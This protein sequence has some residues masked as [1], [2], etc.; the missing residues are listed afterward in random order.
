MQMI[1]IL[2]SLDVA[3]GDRSYPIYIASGLLGRAGK[4]LQDRVGASL[5]VT[6]NVIAPL[7]LQALKNSLA[8]AGIEVR[9]AVII[10]SG[11]SS[12]SF[13]RLD[14]LCN[15]ILALGIDR[16]TTLI[17]LGGGVIGDLAGFA[18][19][20]LLRGL[21]F[22]QIP[23]TLLA[24]VDSSVGGKTGINTPHG[25]NLIGAFYQPKAVLIDLD[26][27]QTLPDRQ[28]RNGYAEIAKYGLINDAG[29]FAWCEQNALLVISRDPDALHHAILHSCRAKATIVAADEREENGQ[30]AL[31]NLGHTFGHAFEAETGYSDRLLH[32][33]AVALG[34]VQAFKLSEK[35][36]LSSAADTRRVVDH[37]NAVGL[38]TDLAPFNFDP[39]ALMAH[40]RKDKKTEK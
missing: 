2:P 20:I 11:E 4:M 31:L 18:A 35:L 6:D 23:T 37:F 15:Q 5:I 14:D 29:F 27:L 33:E 12:K 10:P 17:A 13:S 39:D 40:M 34:I 21:P 30:R 7:H 8:A 28:L 19:A 9:G 26:V 32:G 16:K 24:Q 1:D 3:L 36:Q 38:P 22:V 25:K